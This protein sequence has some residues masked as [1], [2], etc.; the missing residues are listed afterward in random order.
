MSYHTNLFI[1]HLFTTINAD[2]CL[3]IMSKKILP[4]GR[5]P[6]SFQLYN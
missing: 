4:P 3:K 1:T 5:W 2:S 6:L